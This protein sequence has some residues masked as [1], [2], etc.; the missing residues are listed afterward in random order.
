MCISWAR[1]RDRALLPTAV[2]FQVHFFP[3][4]ERKVNRLVTCLQRVHVHV[5]KYRFDGRFGNAYDIACF[6]TGTCTCSPQVPVICAYA[7][8]NR[9]GKKFDGRDNTECSL[10]NHSFWR[11][12]HSSHAALWSVLA[13]TSLIH[14]RCSLSI[15]ISRVAGCRC[16]QVAAEGSRAL[17]LDLSQISLVDTVFMTGYI[18][19]CIYH[20]LHT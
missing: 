12:A 10:L 6:C 4:K 16:R 5:Q 17:T 20:I 8:H 14:L 13:P 7:E 15:C 11:T 18:R 2:F 19:T 1:G 9:P 3:N